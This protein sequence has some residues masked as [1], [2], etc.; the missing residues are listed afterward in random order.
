MNEAVFLL[1]QDAGYLSINLE[2]GGVGVHRE[3]ACDIYVECC[4][5]LVTEVSQVIELSIVCTTRLFKM[6]FCPRGLLLSDRR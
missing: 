4:V 2:P 6:Y 5:L 1:L 3:R